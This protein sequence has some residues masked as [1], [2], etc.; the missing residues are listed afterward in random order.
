MKRHQR[1]AAP[2]QLDIWDRFNAAVA[3]P[4]S[5]HAQK[6]SAAL[7]HERRMG[8]DRPVRRQSKAWNLNRQ[9]VAEIR[10]LVLRRHD[11]PC[12]TD[13]AE[14]YLEAALPHFVKL[15][16][17]PGDLRAM[18]EA[19][20]C[21]LL[22]GIGRGRVLALAEECEACGW[23][24]KDADGIAAHL[25]VTDA[26]RTA[27]GLK[28]I[29]ATDRSRRQ[30]KADRKKRD[31]AY[32][33][34]KR[35]RAGATPRTASNV[36]QAKALGLS[37]STF[38]RRLKA[39]MIAPPEIIPDPISSAVVRSTHLQTTSSVHTAFRPVEVPA[40]QASPSRSVGA[41]GHSPRDLPRAVRTGHAVPLPLPN[42]GVSQPDMLAEWQPLATVATTYLG[43]VMPPELAL[44]V[45]AAQRAR[46]VTQETVA[47]S[48]GIS[49]PQLANALQGRFGLSQ[50]AA[51][52]LRRWLEAA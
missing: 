22:P 17:N 39:G 6:I 1:D 25:R 18:V 51:A 43:G 20:A 27:L 13:D 48:I 40:R 49:R 2:Q 11:G 15:Y 14:I 19:W 37:L 7:E 31:A 28:T 33:A 42:G 50:S 34:E 35:A 36:A 52:N 44:A 29:G 46:M 4:E 10:T 24:M 23:R 41:G 8:R 12:D 16:P 26:E 9:R 32:Q 30:R 45:R 5:V 3:G 38:K 21:T 47:R